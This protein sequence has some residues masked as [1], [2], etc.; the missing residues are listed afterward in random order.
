MNVLVDLLN[1]WGA[2]IWRGSLQGGLAAIVVWC[3]C[4]IAPSIPARFQCWLWRLVMLKFVIALL[5]TVPI[6]ISLL[7]AP[8]PSVWAVKETIQL[9]A[10]PS[11]IVLIDEHQSSSIVPLLLIPFVAWIIIVIY[12]I[13]LLFWAFRHSIRLKNGCRPSDNRQ[14]LDTVN[15]VCKQIGIHSP[16]P[17]LETFGQG[18]PLLIGALRPVIVLPMTTLSRLDASER[19]LVISHELAHACRRDLLWKLVAASVRTIFFFHPLAWFSEQQL[20]LTQEI[21]ADELAIGLHDQNP[22]SYATLLLSIVSK[23]GPDRTV[24]TLSVGAAG[25]HSSLKRRLIAM[26]FM[27]QTSPRFVLIYSLVLGLGVSVG[28]V[29]WTIVLTTASAADETAD[30][31]LEKTPKKKAEDGSQKSKMEYGRFVSMKNRTLTIQT[32]S[33][34]FIENILPENTKTSVWDNSADKY[35]MAETTEALAKVKAGTW[36]VVNVAN[37][38]LTVRIGSRKG[39]TVGT[40]VSFKNDRLLMLGKDLDERFTKKYGNNLHFNKFRDDVPAYESVDGGD[41]Q[42]I[43][44][45]N[46]ALG[47][48]KE[49]TVLTVHAEGDDNITL[50]QIGVAKSK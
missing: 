1:I 16:P 14:V 23:L 15:F 18:S 2:A 35:V 43:G 32:N 41:Y 22:A 27:K 17:L 39:S 38:N 11:D 6:E 34:D 21:A 36:V 12:Q 48:V 8:E 37:E 45:A 20:G 4:Q 24:P 9:S 13:S 42:L 44:M 46:K 5:L 19:T 33:G 25:S 3:T 29:P 40:F 31:V 50:V 28:I 47:N 7:P 49:G 10:V 26:R 30:R